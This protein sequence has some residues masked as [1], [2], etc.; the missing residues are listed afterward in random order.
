MSTSQVVRAII[1]TIRRYSARVGRSLVITPRRCT[2]KR[3]P[4]RTCVRRY[5]L[6]IESTYVTMVGEICIPHQMR[7]IFRTAEVCG[8]TYMQRLWFC[9]SYVLMGTMHICESSDRS[10]HDYHK[11]VLGTGWSGSGN[12]TKAFHAEQPYIH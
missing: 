5:V 7:H 2:L 1:I 12:N 6:V 10:N 4:I 8:C 3:T 11:A 9:L